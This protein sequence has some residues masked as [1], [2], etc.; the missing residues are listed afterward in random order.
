MSDSSHWGNETE[1]KEMVHEMTI[2]LSICHNQGKQEQLKRNPNGIICSVLSNFSTPS[3]ILSSHLF[4]L[5]NNNLVSNWNSYLAAWTIHVCA[6]EKNKA[7]WIC[8]DPNLETL[9]LFSCS[10]KAKSF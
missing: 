9:G 4:F 1:T 10:P 6:N 8:D 7:P 5:S 2:F 3:S